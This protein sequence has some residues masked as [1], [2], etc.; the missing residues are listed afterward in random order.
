MAAKR[1][2]SAERVHLTEKGRPLRKPPFERLGMIPAFYGEFREERKEGPP[3]Q[4]KHP[5]D[6]ACLCRGS[7]NPSG[8][9]RLL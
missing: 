4:I 5:Q 8:S 3:S 7:H 2:A 1:S 6:K 9:D